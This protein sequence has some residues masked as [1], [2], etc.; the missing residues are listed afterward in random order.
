MEALSRIPLLATVNETA[1]PLEVLLLK[2]VPDAL[3]HVTSIVTLSSKDAVLSCVLCWVLLGWPTD[4]PDSHFKPFLF[5]LR[6]LSAYKNCLL[7]GSRV[8][9]PNPV[10]K[11]R[12]TPWQ[13]APERS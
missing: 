3:S 2:M 12:G 9:I 7:L 8:V 11:A 4:V 13:C 5:R 10:R 6:E 1:P